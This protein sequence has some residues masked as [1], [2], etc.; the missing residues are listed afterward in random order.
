VKDRPRGPEATGWLYP[1]PCGRYTAQPDRRAC[2]LSRPQSARG[3]RARRVQSSRRRPGAALR[4]QPARSRGQGT[5]RLRSRAGRAA[6]RFRSAVCGPVGGRGRRN[7]ARPTRIRQPRARS[8]Q[9]LRAPACAYPPSSRPRRRRRRAGCARCLLLRRARR[10]RIADRVSR[11]IRRLPNG[12]TLVTST[13]AFIIAT[14]SAVLT[15]VAVLGFFVWAARKDGE[16]DRMVQSR[17]G[18]RRRTR[19]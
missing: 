5:R 13:A 19:L 2:R 3:L 18:I 15:A 7:C 11:E 10:A 6:A 8:V 16:Y 4:L 14:V 1:S 17:L 12:N 9:P